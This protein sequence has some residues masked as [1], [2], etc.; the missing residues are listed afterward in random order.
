M[1]YLGKWSG[2]K[3]CALSLVAMLSTAASAFAGEA[4]LV[5]PPLQANTGSFQ[6]RWLGIGSSVF[7]LIYRIYQGQKL[8]GSSC[9][10]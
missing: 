4:D 5:V 9:N 3:A 2:W 1:A 10:G 6:L 7:G 8:Q